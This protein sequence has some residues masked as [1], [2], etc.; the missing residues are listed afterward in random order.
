M[1]RITNN[2]LVTM[3]QLQQQMD[4]TANNLSNLD[5]T[6]YKAR[7]GRFNELLSQQMD[8]Q[9]NV[10]AEV[11]RVTPEGIR[12]GNGARLTDTFMNTAPGQLKQTERELDL[13]LGTENQYFRVEVVTDAG[14]DVQFTRQGNFYTSPGAAGQVYLVTSDGSRVLDSNGTPIQLPE[15]ASEITFREDGTVLYTLPSGEQETHMQQV[16]V[17]EILKPQLMTAESGR[18]S[19]PDLGALGVDEGQVIANVAAEN[20]SIIQSSLEG[21]NVN[22]SQELTDMMKAQRAYQMNSRSISIA[23]Q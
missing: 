5:T 20:R 19:L 6:G 22:L 11:G 4:L 16:G 23:D 12:L 7:H 14:T 2:A 1:Y 13:A 9:R 18:L 15:N 17:A 10:G 8:N 21:S 3:T